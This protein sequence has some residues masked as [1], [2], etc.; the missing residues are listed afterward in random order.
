VTIIEN[1]LGGP[2]QTNDNADWRH[3]SDTIVTYTATKQVS[4][5]ANYDYG[6]EKVS[7]TTVKWQGVAGYLKYQANDWFALVPRAEY[8]DDTKGGFLTAGSAFQTT[9]F[10]SSAGKIKEFTLTAE[11]K[12]KDGVMM[13]LEYR[14]DFSDSPFFLKNFDEPAKKQNTFTVGMVYAFSS[15][16]P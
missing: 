4:L 8:L 15:K 1:Y 11:F 9:G 16:A 7:G 5:A 2:E 10:A 14:G 12:H 13:R 3:L 6:Q